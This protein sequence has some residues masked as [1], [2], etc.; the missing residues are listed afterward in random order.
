MHEIEAAMANVAVVDVERVAEIKQ[1]ISEGRFKVD[2]ERVA[3]SLIQ[4]VRQMLAVTI[5]QSVSAGSRTRRTFL[6]RALN[7][8]TRALRAFIG[9]LEDEQRCAV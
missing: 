4:S 1:A 5:R 7:E 3:D 8:E 6:A 2:A 9:L